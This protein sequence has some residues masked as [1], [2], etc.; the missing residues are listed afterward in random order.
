MRAL[1]PA[2]VKAPHR[3]PEPAARTVRAGTVSGKSDVM[4]GPHS[5]GSGG[6]DNLNQRGWNVIEPPVGGKD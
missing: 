1:G 6:F 4:V 5:G 3:D 2:G